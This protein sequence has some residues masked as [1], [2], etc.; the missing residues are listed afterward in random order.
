MYQWSYGINIHRSF[1]NMKD[2]WNDGTDGAIRDF[3][4]LLKT[5]DIKS[6]ALKLPALLI[7]LPKLID[8]IIT[9]LK[10]CIGVHQVYIVTFKNVGYEHLFKIGYTK[11]QPITKRFAEKRYGVKLIVKDIIRQDELPAMGAVEFEKFIKTELPP[12]VSLDIENPGKGEF[13]DIT[14][15]DSVLTLWESNLDKYENVRGL[16]SPN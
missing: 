12:T 14:M 9:T 2:F 16:K 5:K 3:E 10:S 7:R 1:Y 6:I 11:H 13:Y 4:T 8:Y 15:L